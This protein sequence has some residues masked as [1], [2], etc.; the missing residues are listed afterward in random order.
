MVSGGVE[1]SIINFLEK[2][3]YSKH[4]VDL[5]LNHHVGEFYDFIPR[6]V[7]L[8]NV[9]QTSKNNS[10]MLQTSKQPSIG[11]KGLIIK[12]LSN[13]KILQKLGA[14]KLYYKKKYGGLNID[15]E[16]DIAIVHNVYLNLFYIL[17]DK[18]RASYKCAICHGDYGFI[19]KSIQKDA[20]K[21][22][23]K[24]DKVYFVSESCEKRFHSLH[25]NSKVNTSFVY[26][27][28]DT[29]EIIEK[30]KDYDV[31]Y[32]DAFNIVSVSRMSEEKAH[33]RTLSVLK[34][35]KDEGIEFC[36][37]IVGDGPTRAAIE[38]KILEYGLGDCVKLY[39][40]QKNPYPYVKKADLF[41]LGSYHEA[42]PMVYAESMSLGVPV[43]TTETC[44]A[45][46][47]VG[48]FGFVCGNNEQDIYSAFKIIL[49]NNEL[50]NQKR[51]LL[52]TYK[53]DNSLFF[54]KITQDAAK[55]N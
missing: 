41:Y 29:D 25:K 54:D 6:G 9:S 32:G 30:S 42:A 19:K 36:W 38:E 55:K 39:G 8:L 12:A 21:E 26:N 31:T 43:L 53:Y 20:I 5:Y 48:D 10:D 37:N 4:E 17:L 46:E 44:S 40:N 28:Q 52:K 51:E 16:Y 27:M 45:K 11:I 22:Y 14:R 3:D 23:R 24:L 34:R 15:K 1:K 13:C 7:N 35:L 2:I 50:L 49:Q 18:V 47:L 33:L